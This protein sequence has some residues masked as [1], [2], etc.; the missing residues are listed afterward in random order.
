MTSADDD[1][2]VLVEERLR[3]LEAQR[4]SLRSD[5]EQMRVSRSLD[6]TDDEHDPEGSTVSLDHARDRALLAATEQTLA[7]L[8][9]ARERLAAG[10]FGRCEGCG[11]AI[12]EERLR[13]RPEARYCISCASRQAGP[14]RR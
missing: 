12:P 14:R 6:F 2:V 9:A 7:E 3:E 4:A 10:S 5:V 8:V 1:L 11:E 13:A